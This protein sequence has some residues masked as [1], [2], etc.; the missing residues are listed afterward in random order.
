[1][2]CTNE[3]DNFSLSNRNARINYPIGLITADET[4]LAGAVTWAYNMNYYLYAKAYYWTM[5]PSYFSSYDSSA[6]EFYVASSGGLSNGGIW[7]DVGLR[8]LISLF[9]GTSIKSGNGTKGNPYVIA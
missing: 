3:T 2:K 5:S 1:M 6:R 7:L 9:L 8:P 4:R